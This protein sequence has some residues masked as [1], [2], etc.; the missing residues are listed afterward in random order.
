M[1]HPA[2]PSDIAREAIKRLAT[3]KQPPTPDNFRRAYNEV[4]GKAGEPAAWPQAIRDLLKQWDNYQAGLTQAKKRDMLE[5]V[6]INFGNDPEQLAAKIAGLVRNWSEAQA[7][8]PAVEEGAS[9]AASPVPQ[10]ES[11]TASL[12]PPRGAEPSHL[13]ELIAGYLR[14]LGTDCGQLWPDLASRSQALA[15]AIAGRDHAL[16]ETHVEKMGRLW[17]EILVRAEDGHDHA[18]GLKRLLSLLFEN[19]AQLV[20]EDAWLSGQLAAMRVTLDGDLTSHAL[21][22]A[23]RSLQEVVQRQQN[24]KGSLNEAKEKLR[25]L[26][27][28]F[29]DRVGEIS[30]STGD[31]HGRIE[32]Y[33]ERIAKADDISQLSDVIDSLS[34]DML[35]IRDAMKHGHEELVQARS[36]VQ[37]AEHRIL[38]LEREL[39]EVSSLVRED[40]LTGALNRRGMDE[41][42]DREISRATRAAASLSV[43]LMDIDHFKKLN[44][45]L[46]H[47]VGDQALVHLSRVVK[48]LLRPT[49][50]LARYGGEEF[51]ILLPNTDAGEGQQVMQRVQRDLTKEYFMHDNQKVLITFS[52]GVA[53]MRSGESRD[54]LIDRADAAMYWAK[55]S[56]RN[57]VEL[58]E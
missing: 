30:A 13:G 19:V 14:V 49:D 12:T 25:H 58:A 7:D 11:A 17:R 46:G 32:S 9:I 2:Q 10:G 39:E 42:F 24:L 44:D 52:A 55:A 28:T 47:Q 21:F 53:E 1:E 6:L 31:Y 51:L 18:G 27:S 37:E 34:A 20:S 50:V 26:I 23:E 4:S 45:T 54:R 22:E 57:R 5:R 29:I 16:D 3:R 38:T 15:D 56:G 43:A 33:S 8:V 40:Q 41:A 35:Q 48:K 36:H